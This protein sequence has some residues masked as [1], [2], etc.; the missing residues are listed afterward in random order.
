MFAPGDVVFF[1]SDGAGKPKFHICVALNGG[2]FYLNSPKA[3]THPGDFVFSCSELPFLKPTANGSSIISCNTVLRLS[4]QKL[5]KFRAEKKGEMNAGLIA[6]L[7]GFVEAT[8]VLTDAE[9]E[10]IVDALV[11]RIRP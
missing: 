8:P 3:R 2:F 4:P 10:E 5:K 6:G 7:I 9:K 11:D 1:W